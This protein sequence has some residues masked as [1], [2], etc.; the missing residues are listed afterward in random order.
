MR[1]YVRPT[2]LRG[3]AVA[4]DKTS[5]VSA[6]FGSWIYL[7]DS[8]ETYERL[9][10]KSTSPD[11]FT[12]RESCRMFV[13]SSPD[14]SVAPVAGTSGWFQFVSSDA[15]QRLVFDV[16][17]LPSITSQYEFSDRDKV[18][19]DD[20]GFYS[21]NG[22]YE[23][24]LRRGD[25]VCFIDV[26]INPETMERINLRRKELL[27]LNDLLRHLRAFAGDSEESM[28]TLADVV[29]ESGGLLDTVYTEYGLVVRPGQAF[30]HID[31]GFSITTPFARAFAAAIDDLTGRQL[32]VK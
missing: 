8:N 11:V 30:H 19:I 24:A 28:K 22:V 20:N 14:T 2:A 1:T 15:I 27:V 7:H 32:V 23:V 17:Q 31:R 25:H 26:E 13:A 10:D 21:E 29:W 3:T 9:L 18:I 16:Y 4:A 5:A 6:P 12:W